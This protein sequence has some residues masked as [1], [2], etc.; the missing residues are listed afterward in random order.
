MD[1]LEI[2]SKIGFDWR[3]GLANLVNFLIIFWLLKRFAW[4]PIQEKIKQRE[5]KIEKGLEDAEKAAGELAMAQENYN[6]KINEAKKESNLIIAKATEQGR[7]LINQAGDKAERRANQI[8]AQAK[9]TISKEK[10]KML[11]DVKNE[12]VNIAFEITGKILK[13]K[14]NS[15][16]DAQLIKKLISE[17]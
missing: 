6:K 12:T 9:K 10:E 3:M 5:D 1:I 7:E 11:S 2:L 8:I 17:K 14:L 16:T 4:K 15:K 13:Q